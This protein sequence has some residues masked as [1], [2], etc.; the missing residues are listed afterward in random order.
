M[1]VY[2]LHLAMRWWRPQ[3]LLKVHM[4]ACSGCQVQNTEAHLA[5]QQPH[6]TLEL[7]I[8]C[9]QLLV[10]MVQG[11]HMRQPPADTPGWLFADMCLLRL[12]KLVC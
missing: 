10:L 3:M 9:L 11:V 4:P 8:C 12:L 6:V 7:L 2:M 1:Q 5:Q